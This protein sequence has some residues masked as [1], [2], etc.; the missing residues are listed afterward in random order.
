MNLQYIT[1]LLKIKT[2]YQQ[3]LGSLKLSGVLYFS[4]LS[5]REQTSVLTKSRQRLQHMYKIQV[6]KEMPLEI[7]NHISTE[8]IFSIHRFKVYTIAVFIF[9]LLRLFS[10]Y[11]H[12][13]NLK[14]TH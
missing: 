2:S 6:H 9:Y 12:F 4:L 14:W 3:M 8:Y 11:L 7:L 10:F 13:Y 5:K 1:N